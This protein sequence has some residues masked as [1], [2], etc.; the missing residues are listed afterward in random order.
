MCQVTIL[1]N[2]TARMQSWSELSVVAHDRRH[3]SDAEAQ[4][5]CYKLVW[6][7]VSILYSQRWVKTS[8]LICD[9][10]SFFALYFMKIQS[11]PVISTLSISNNRLSRREN[12]VP[13][14]TGNKILWKRVEIAHKEQSLLFSTMFSIH[15]TSGVKLHIHLWNVDLFF[16]QFCKSEMRGTDITKYFRKSLRLRDNVSRL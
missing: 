9:W 7:S 10:N 2:Q 4:I 5:F 16:L 12:L 13:V 11:T 15:L 8:L 1:I 14:L 3:V 6:P